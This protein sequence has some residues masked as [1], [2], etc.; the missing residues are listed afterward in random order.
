MSPIVCYHKCRSKGFAYFALQYYHYCYCGNSYN[1]YGK[2]PS[3]E[4]RYKC[5]GDKSKMCGGSWRNSVYSTGL[6]GETSFIVPSRD[7]SHVTISQNCVSPI[8]VKQKYRRLGCYLDKSRRDVVLSL[9]NDFKLTVEKCGDKCKKKGYQYFALQYGYQ[10]YCGN[11]YGRYGKR[12][13]TE[14]AYK[15]RGDSSQYCG[16]AYRNDVYSTGVSGESHS[17][18][19]VKK[20]SHLKWPS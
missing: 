15:C 19:E 18:R 10:C 17:E 6:T 12:S 9:G 7:D 16:G 4:C 20:K 14:C 1:M 8:S 13:D 5:S 2:R 3:S 11:H